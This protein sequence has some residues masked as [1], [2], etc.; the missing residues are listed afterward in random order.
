MQLIAS[1]LLPLANCEIKRTIRIFCILKR[2]AKEKSFGAS[3][4]QRTLERQDSLADSKCRRSPHKSQVRRLFGLGRISFEFG[5]LIKIR[6]TYTIKGKIRR[7]FLLN[8]A[9]LG[10]L[11]N[12]Q[13]SPPE[14]RSASCARSRSH[15]FTYN[16]SER[17]KAFSFQSETFCWSFWPAFCCANPPGVLGS[18]LSCLKRLQSLKAIA[19]HLLQ[20]ETNSKF[21]SFESELQTGQEMSRTASKKNHQDSSIQKE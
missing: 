21:E 17:D 15:T 6:G 18:F 1:E 16:D 11:A 10:D 8:V 9:P 3:S 2:G 14:L 12:T 4:L 20:I 7:R 5:A 13:G 19:E